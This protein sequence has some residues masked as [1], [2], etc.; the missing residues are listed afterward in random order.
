MANQ[1]ITG[2]VIPSVPSSPVVINDQIQPFLHKTPIPS[3]DEETTKWVKGAQTPIQEGQLTPISKALNLLVGFSSGEVIME[4]EE[5]KHIPS[6]SESLES[7][8]DTPKRK[9]TD[10]HANRTKKAKIAQ[11][12]P[13]KNIC[14]QLAILKPHT[15]VPNSEI[16][17]E[18]IIKDSP[19]S[20][21]YKINTLPRKGKGKGVKNIKINVTGSAS[22]MTCTKTTLMAKQRSAQASKAAQAT[23]S[24]IPK[25]QQTLSTGK[26][27]QKQLATKAAHKQGSGQGVK[28]KP[29]R[30]YAMIALHEIRCFQKSVDLLIP[31]LPFQRLVREIAQDCK[32]DLRFQSSTILALQEAAEAWLVGLFKSANLCCIHKGRQTIAP[33]DFYLVWRIHHIAGTNLWWQ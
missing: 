31:L 12:E 16:Q 33:K 20:V 28:T 4:G 26:A 32:M 2:D 23:K 6:I 7:I 27:P 3:I 15:K 9:N 1:I 19:S 24:A 25:L 30:S 10:G 29:R 21:P 18:N 5:L 13:R 14:K 22:E 11:K 8:W 17:I